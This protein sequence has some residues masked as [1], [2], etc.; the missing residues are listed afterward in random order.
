MYTME[1]EVMSVKSQIASTLLNVLVNVIS[2]DISNGKTGII[3]RYNFFRFKKK[4]KK[5]IDDF[6]KKH[7]ETILCSGKF[8]MYLTYQHPT[9]KIFDYVL[10]PSRDGLGDDTF[11]NQIVKEAREYLI[12]EN[13]SLSVQDESVI[14]ELFRKIYWELDEYC[15]KNLSL[16][17]GYTLA[18]II[19][20]Q[21]R[22]TKNIIE[23]MQEV[24]ELLMCKDSIN[25]PEVII[26]IYTTLNDDMFSGNIEDVHNILPIL[27]GK[28][29]D[30]DIAIRIKM[31]IISDFICL[32]TDMI[33]AWNQINSTFISED[34]A[35]LLILYWI[36][37][38]AKLEEL[39]T[40]LK[41][42]DL[43]QIVEILINDK[44]EH[45]LK[46]DTEKENHV[47]VIKYT[48]TDQYK[49]QDWL[50]K[51][52]CA[53]S[54]YKESVFNIYE[55]M[56]KTLELD[57][58]F[59]DKLFIIDKEQ[60]ELVSIAANEK[61]DLFRLNAIKVCLLEMKDKFFHANH[62]LKEK[63]FEVLLRT[64]V[65]SA[66]EELE[67]TIRDCPPEIRKKIKIKS[68]I[69]QDKINKR[70]VSEKE[71][72][73][74]C[75][76]AG[77]YWL[78]NNYLIG[79][80]NDTVKLQNI[81]ERHAEILEKDIGIFMMY[82]QAI[83][84]N[85]GKEKA[86]VEID[87]YRDLYEDHLE[88]LMEYSKL[89]DFKNEILQKLYDKW[90]GGEYK[91]INLESEKDFAKLLIDQKKYKE[92]YQVIRKIETLGNISSEL[93]RLKAKVLV[94]DNQVINALN[95]LRKVFDDYSE[96]PFVVDTIIVLSL[97]GQREIAQKVIDAAIKIGTDRLFM[98]VAVV[99]AR[100]M[101]YSDAKYFMTK[102]LLTSDGNNIDIYG[103][104][105]MLDVKAQDGS[106]R[107]IT[108]V[109]EDTAVFLASSSGEKKVYCVYKDDVLP[110]EPY[111]WENA[112]HIYRDIAISLGLLRKKTHETIVIADIEYTITEV[113]PIECYLFRL[114]MAKLVETRIIKEFSI[115][116]QIDGKINEDKLIE[117][118]KEYIPESENSFDWLNNY[119][120]L[121]NMP[122][123][124][125][126]LQRNVRVNNVQLIISLMQDSGIII[127]ELYNVTFN[128]G[129]MYILTLASAVM[130][131]M[132]GVNVKYLNKK[133]IIISTSLQNTLVDMCMGIIDDNDK[134]TVSSIGIVQDHLF[135]NVVSEE[136]KIRI[137]REAAE[138]KRFVLEL[139]T[140]ENTSDIT[141]SSIDKINLMDI[142]G[143][144]DYDALAI[145][146]TTKAVVVTGEVTIMAFL[147]MKEFGAS[148]ITIINF[149]SVIQIEI[150]ELLDCM[151]KMEEFEFLITM[152][153]ESITYLMEMYNAIEDDDK[154]EHCM[155]KWI[156]YLSN[157]E[158]MSEEYKNIFVQNITDVY[159]VMYDQ[160]IGNTNPI[161][162][163][164][165][166]FLMKYNHIR[167]EVR[168]GE[169]GNI[170]VLT[171]RVVN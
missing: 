67:D 144:S 64:L 108:G 110:V 94:E 125:H 22:Q 26:R 36:E 46:V 140:Q 4:N 81:I 145:A 132:L 127:R 80:N 12:S 58:N 143:I 161:W 70:D 15:K 138:L 25:D 8:E 156:N 79:F 52:I 99:Y 43:K 44:H 78:F 72:L 84:I 19:N 103:N 163:N 51:R 147:Q 129:D 165:V 35:Q 113:M 10:N 24:K 142:F 28:N 6:C 149:L 133:N 160:Q 95:I 89:S 102:S 157:P 27:T 77:Q 11:I 105:F 45:I 2:S 20:S 61:M 96:D 42:Q 120:D 91:L 87:K 18:A 136:E 23:D 151:E 33:K 53:Y 34:V 5:W 1:G 137:M 21:A 169:D 38:K 107:K 57:M 101:R 158:N 148:G 162:T 62:Q 98:L 86:I 29:K 88:Y 92:A 153:K 82:I 31:S 56:N 159:K 14:K 135:M 73:D 130:L 122:L 66:S 49:K 154:K 97:N 170:E 50:I 54:L 155:E 32:D 104:Y 106:E 55:A 30:L 16:G 171:H 131:Y 123:P 7:D 63:F 90:K 68:L 59:I 83:R 141:N 146:Q 117:N 76:E 65:I 152:T 111:C 167:M 134:D 115:E 121:S 150:S 13:S 37:N 109:E 93:L 48:V 17:E 164:F 112:T 69:L 41:N 85:N 100:K 9:K 166:Y 128:Q 60:E 74:V 126:L 114:C 124:F 116:T 47:N 139:N 168:F 3:E 40:N 75:E 71:I 118:L 39:H 119:K